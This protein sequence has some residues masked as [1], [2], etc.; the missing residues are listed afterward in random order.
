MGKVYRKKLK[1]KDGSFKESK[2]Y[3]LQYY[4]NCKLY[5]E[6]T[7]LTSESDA[8]KLLKIRETQMIAKSLKKH[9]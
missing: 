8:R 3:T 6:N 1:L 5:D 2:T 9:S 4:R 7:S